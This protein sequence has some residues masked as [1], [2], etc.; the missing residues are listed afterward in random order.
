MKNLLEQK[1]LVV[2]VLV[3][4]VV[5]ISLVG[6]SLNL[7]KYKKGFRDEMALRLDLE[8]KILRIE[9]ERQDMR[10]QLEVLKGEASENAG[11]VKG[12][13]EKLASR[14]DEIAALKASSARSESQL[15]SPMQK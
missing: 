12:L 5:L 8:E 10:A 14:E 4:I 15:K 3:T 11:E 9:K 6:A 13:K 7:G 1:V 2:S